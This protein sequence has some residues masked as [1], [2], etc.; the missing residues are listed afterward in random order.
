[1]IRFLTL[2]RRE[3]GAYFSS[4]VAY[5]LASFFL[6]VMGLGFWY[7]ASARLITGAAVY[8][9]FRALYG[10]VAWVAVLMVVPVLTMRSFAEEKRS[11]TLETLLTAPVSDWQV[12][13]AKFAGVFT[14][15]M[16]FW[17]PTLLYFPMLNRLNGGELPFDRG[18]LAATYL[19]LALIGAFFLSV[20]LFLSSLTRNLIVAAMATFAVLMLI[21]LAGFLPEISPVPFIQEASRPFSVVLHMLDFSRGILDSRPV[22]LY[23]S[24][25]VWMLSACTRS[26]ESRRWRS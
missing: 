21:F 14:L 22:I 25:T 6:A 23:L 24:S 3:L 11:G 15:Y 12:V 4:A 26:L 2:W 13:L 17:L 8:D 1:M 19:G 20:G 5:I 7:I 10:G 9:L 18:A 16:L